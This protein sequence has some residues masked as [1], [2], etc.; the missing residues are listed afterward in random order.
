VGEPNWTFRQITDLELSSFTVVGQ[1]LRFSVS[2]DQAS[3]P[4]VFSLAGGQL[5]R[6]VDQ[7]WAVEVHT[8]MDEWIDL[9][10]WLS[11]NPPA[12]F[13]S[14]KSSFQGMNSMPPPAMVAQTL[15]AA[16]VECIDWN[17]C[18]IEVEFDN[19]R[20]NGLLTVH[21]FLRGRLQGTQN[22]EALIYDHRSGEAAD[23]IAITREP[24]DKLKVS[25]YHC[26]GAGGE[27]SGGRVGDV[28][29]VTCQILKSV[30]FCEAEVLA[31]HL[32]HRVNPHRHTHPSSFVIGD[33]E[34]TK[35]L[36]LQTPVDRISF[37]IY[38]V[39]PGIS[40]AALDGHLTDLM[41]F[42]LDYVLRGGAASG[43]WLISR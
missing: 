16:D 21:E 34:S 17:G 18:A 10:M 22:V 30:A 13:A 7:N 19:T 32:E 29:E 5:I 9:P 37:A 20:A 14:D 33:L 12:F 6:G 11:L 31:K 25:L 41:A 1:E 28:Y 36:L 38:G 27:P 35:A 4:L 26:K 15:A 42:S 40:A 8:H 39:Q 43:Q 3:I 23:F 2:S 24:D